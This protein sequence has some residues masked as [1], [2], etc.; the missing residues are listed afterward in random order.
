MGRVALVTGGTRGI[1]EAIAE[2]LLGEGYAVV[3]CGRSAPET[4]PMAGDA[5]AS[6]VA[7]DVRS[8]E[9]VAAM[10][11]GV[12]ASHGRLDLLVN[13]AGGSPGVAAADAS[14]RL[15]EKIVALNLLG[16]LHASQAAHRVMRDQP[17]G[18]AI[19]NIASVSGQRAS[20][21]TAAYGAAKAGLLSLSKS[22]AMEWGPQVRVNA[23]VVGLVD[24]EDA[25]G[26]YGGAEGKAR[27]AAALPLR[28]MAQGED[29]A[30]IVA[31]LASPAAAY[32]SGAEIAVH[33]GGEPPAFLALAA[34]RLSAGP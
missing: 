4:L 17:G 24:A 25:D 21:G 32:V 29:V 14:P 20:P 15:S 26:H 33:G 31:F 12:R 18:G 5:Q 30:A 34:G 11:E 9:A 22:L 13:N 7:C 2:K 23:V 28:R 19:V 27:I 10:I 6:F 1:G 3:V 8:A 16:P